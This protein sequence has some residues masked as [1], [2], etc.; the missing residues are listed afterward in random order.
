MIDVSQFKQFVI[1]PALRAIGLYSASAG[2]LLLGTA[3]QESKLTYLHQLGGGPACGVFQ[4][5]PNT[6]KDIWNNYLKYKP[7]LVGK[8]SRAAGPNKNA[9][10]MIADLVFAAMMCRVHYLRVPAAL[11]AAGDYEG[12]AE[13]WKKYYNTYL[14]H[15]TVEQ[16]LDNW[17][18]YSGVPRP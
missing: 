15:G 8:I 4:M 11:P 2:E 18:K 7:D 6:Y 5:E 14:G 10:S 1:E 17:Y 3:L 12:Q 16:Y 9:Q 13:Y